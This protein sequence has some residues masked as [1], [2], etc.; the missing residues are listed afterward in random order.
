[1]GPFQ[2]NSNALSSILHLVII[3]Y[4]SS[5]SYKESIKLYKITCWTARVLSISSNDSS[6]HWHHSWKVHWFSITKKSAI[7]FNNINGY[8]ITALMTNINKITF[9]YFIPDCDA[10]STHIAYILICIQRPERQSISCARPLIL[11]LLELGRAG[12][13]LFD[14]C[15]LDH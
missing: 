3:N 6:G 9:I 13:Q 7:P 2:V 14:D 11:T 4:V 8:A 10:H 5:Y 15:K 1:M 12:H